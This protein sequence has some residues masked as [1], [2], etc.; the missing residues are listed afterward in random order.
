[1]A[2]FD[3]TLRERN[4]TFH[5]DVLHKRYFPLNVAKIFSRYERSRIFNAI[6]ISLSLRFICIC[7]FLERVKTRRYIV[8]ENTMTRYHASLSRPFCHAITFRGTLYIALS[9]CSIVF[10]LAETTSSNILPSDLRTF[11]TRRVAT[12]HS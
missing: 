9:M 8:R 4:Y 12:L 3:S 6:Y 11:S 2:N 5:R 7:L 1:M 10:D